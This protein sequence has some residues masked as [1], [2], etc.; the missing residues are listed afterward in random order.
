MKIQDKYFTLKTTRGND[1]PVEKLETWE[2]VV[3]SDPRTS[4]R[5]ATEVADLKYNGWNFKNIPTGL[6]MYEN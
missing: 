4:V 1:V 2:N 6:Y 5:Y 3:V